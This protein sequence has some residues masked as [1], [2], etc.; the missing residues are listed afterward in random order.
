M[1][2]SKNLLEILNKS[3]VYSSEL[4]LQ[5]REFWFNNKNIYK[6]IET[7]V[8]DFYAERFFEDLFERLLSKQNLCFYL[9]DIEYIL[10]EKPKSSQ[11]NPNETEE[12]YYNFL[13]KLLDLTIPSN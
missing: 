10:F 9:Q 12:A 8:C 1:H 3:A 5:P 6:L 11:N 2:F 4:S 7:C 13:V